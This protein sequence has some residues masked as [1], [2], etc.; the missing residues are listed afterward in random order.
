MSS[1][2]YRTLGLQPGASM[3]D[4]KR[5]YRRLAKA[6]HPDSAGEAALPRFLAI[7][8]AYEHLRTGRPLPGVRPTAG[9]SSRPAAEP[10]R[11]DPERAR[12]ARERA[13]TARA[14]RPGAG[15]GPATSRP[16][17]T[18]AGT[19]SARPSG[20][21]PSAAGA[22][23]A[24]GGP[25]GT[26]GGAASGSAGAFGRSRTA[27]GRRETRKATMGSTSY[28]DA[29]DPSEATWSGASW[30]GPTTGE[31]WIVNPREYADPRKHGPDYQ[32]R[33]R[34]PL[35]ADDPVI[36]ELGDAGPD[37][38]GLADGVAGAPAAGAGDPEAGI[39]RATRGA[40][41]PG[42]RPSPRG[43]ATATG[44]A[45]DAGLDPAMARTGAT[46]ADGAAA[47]PGARSAPGAADSRTRASGELD[48]SRRGSRW[49]RLGD[50]RPGVSWPAPPPP[51]VREWLG[52]AADDPVR[53]LGL[54]LVAW[55]P[56]GLAAAAAIGEITGCSTYSADCGGSD[57]LLPWLAQAGILGLLLL[58]PPIARLLAA[59]A[60]AVVLALVP[61][62]GFLVVVGASGQA[63]A[64]F[65][66]AFLLALAWLAG[67]GW[68]VAMARRRSGFGRGGA[69]P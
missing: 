66:L 58:L 67:V 55:P 1:D 29:R 11:A 53:R 23:G 8:A 16:G 40:P 2:P 32:S 65:A 13:R 34:R 54:A 60:V 3:A 42:A 62:T 56:I 45:W 4:V 15:T 18:G 5:A 47:R 44:A 69:V 41:G 50:V 33:A 12:A 51:P 49:S 22:A 26:T 46:T 52:G 17:S 36:D 27:G 14:G 9:V 43:R 25:T 38:G 30:Y 48:A 6:Y 59:G 7:H 28:D 31:Y 19:G 37:S 68:S 10:W 57:A 35:E 61:V 63:Q 39:G 20:G 21:G 24:A 64:G